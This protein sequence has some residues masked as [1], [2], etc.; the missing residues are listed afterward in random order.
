MSKLLQVELQ[1]SPNFTFAVE[2]DF[3]PRAEFVYLEASETPTVTEVRYSWTFTGYLLGSTENLWSSIDTFRALVE[4]RTAH[5]TWV[6]L[7]RDPDGDNAA[8]WTLDNDTYEQLRLEEFEIAPDST[9]SLSQ[10]GHL[11]THAAITL[12]VSAVKKSADADGIVGWEQE[13]SYSSVNGLRVIEWVTRLSTRGG[14]N[15][16]DALAKARSFAAIDITLLGDSTW[17][18]Q[19]GNTTTDAGVEVQVLDANER[20]SRTPTVVEAVSRVAQQGTVVGAT[21]AGNAPNEITV[22]TQTRVTADETETTTSVEVRGPNATQA[23][24]AHKPLGNLA[25]SVTESTTRNEFFGRW[26]K[27]TSR[28]G[29]SRTI[30]VRLSG[31]RPALRIQP[32]VSGFEPVAQRG[33][34]L[35]FE[36]E[37]RV[38][39][40]RQGG[41]G[42]SS[43]LLLPPLLGDPW[44]LDPAR[45]S[46]GEPVI[47][48][49]RAT[50]PTQN[51]WARTATLVYGATRKPNVSPVRELLEAENTVESY[52]L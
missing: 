18:Y 31:G 47:E 24:L 30:E 40:R 41:Q 50:D 10:A 42:L 34:L 7:V 38:T 39:V 45:S 44:I 29:S 22:R 21:G 26:V 37:V 5:P 51:K 16:V 15:P 46:E 35:P 8:V 48:G 49:E 13:V 32:I 28:S 17:A 14:D 9:F 27:K 36:V 3:V 23:G 25:E 1:G 33:G 20:D 52:V 12:R 6:R 4:S 43:D 2:G 19:T 11:S